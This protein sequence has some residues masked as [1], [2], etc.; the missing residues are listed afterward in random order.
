[1][2]ESFFLSPRTALR[3]LDLHP[4]LKVADLAAGAGF[5]ARAAARQVAPAEVWAVDPNPELL[6]RLKNIAQEERLANLEVVRGNIEAPQGTPLPAGQF[7]IALV[8]NALFA[9]RH[10]DAV[11]REAA[12]VLKRGGR[13]LVIDWS[14][15]HGG[16]GPHETHV[17]AE[18][19]AR[20]L[21]QEAGLAMLGRAEAGAYH[22]G[23]ILSKK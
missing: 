13:A 10:R 15:S 5:F 20:A 1:M 17:C 8:V 7:D 6:A 22:W 21:A 12:R 19:E 4:G 16:L 14:D 18:D 2:S 3:A 9:A 23:V 11:L